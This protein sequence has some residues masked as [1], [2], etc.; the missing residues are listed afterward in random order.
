MTDLK[1]VTWNANGILN[2]INEIEMYITQNNIDILLISETHL[3]N[4]KYVHFT[5]YDSYFTNH[6]DGTAHGGTG[7]II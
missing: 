3:T 2:H 4:N 1:I 6:P 7:I 5:G